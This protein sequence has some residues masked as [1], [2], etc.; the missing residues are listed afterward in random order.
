MKTKLL[1]GG[2][3]VA[4]LEVFQEGQQLGK[5]VLTNGASERFPYFPVVLGGFHWFGEF[6][7]E[8]AVFV[9]EVISPAS[10]V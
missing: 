9:L 10:V 6:L 8:I 4:L 1:K 3:F 7:G 5:S 2:K